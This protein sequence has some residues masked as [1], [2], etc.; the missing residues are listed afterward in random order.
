MGVAEGLVLGMYK[1]GA[2]DTGHSRANA[3]FEFEE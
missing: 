3:S 1:P 2:G